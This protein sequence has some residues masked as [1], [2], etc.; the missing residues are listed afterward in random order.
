M[1]RRFMFMASV[2]GLV[3][4]LNVQ[5]ANAERP[6]QTLP[7]AAQQA[8]VYDRF[9]ADDQPQVSEVLNLTLP[10]VPV[11]IDNAGPKQA[12]AALLAYRGRALHYVYTGQADQQDVVFVF[13]NKRTLKQF[14][15]TNRASQ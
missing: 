15:D 12:P 6:V 3:A 2:V 4:G 13:T 10:E 14:L 9:F 5:S 11:I 7:P 8:A 1:F